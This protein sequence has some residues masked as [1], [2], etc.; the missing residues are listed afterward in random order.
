MSRQSLSDKLLSNL[1]LGQTLNLIPKKTTKPSTASLTASNLVS[2]TTA[3]KNKTTSNKDPLSQLGFTP[4]PNELNYFD[5]PTYHFK[6]SMIADSSTDIKNSNK[7]I[8]AESGATELNIL[9]VR[10]SECLAPNFKTKNTQWISFEI[11]IFE[12]MGADFYNKLAEA[13]EIL[14]VSNIQKCF[15][16]L[17]LYF[18]GYDPTSGKPSIING[19]KWNWPL[20]IVDITSQLDASGCKHTLNMIVAFCAASTDTYNVIPQSFKLDGKTLGDILDSLATNMNQQ[21]LSTYLFPMI[22]YKFKYLPY[23]GSDSP[24][25]TPGDHI[26]N[27]SD[28]TDVI[29]RNPDGAQ[30]AS[31][32]TIDAL[33]GSLMSNSTTACQLI[34]PGRKTTN[35]P[36]D[37]ENKKPN[38]YY[39]TIKTD[40]KL[41]AYHNLYGD[42]EREITYTLVPYDLTRLYGNFSKTD[43]ISNKDYNIKKLKYII[44]KKY[45]NKL[46]DYIFTGNNTEVLSFDIQSNFSYYAIQDYMYGMNHNNSISLGQTDTSNIAPTN[47]NNMQNSI[48]TQGGATS[49]IQNQILQNLSFQKDLAARKKKLNDAKIRLQ[50]NPSDK[51]LAAN[52]AAIEPEINGLEISVNRNTQNLINSDAYKNYVASETQARQTKAQ[53]LAS[54]PTESYLDSYDVSTLKSSTISNSPQISLKYDVFDQTSTSN[55]NID[56]APDNRRSMFMSMLQQLYEPTGSSL[57]S[58]ALKVRGDPYWLGASFMGEN[59]NSLDVATALEQDSVSLSGFPYSLLNETTFVLRFNAPSGYDSNNNV[60]L[61][62]NNYYS[63]FYNCIQVDHIFDGGEYT[64][65]LNGVLIPGT[66]YTKILGS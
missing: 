47:I 24:V 55:Y 4:V 33:I 63:G 32:T 34:N 16:N 17:E 31:G 52:I 41:G 43:D 46:Y 19:R 62:K 5:N 49:N 26:V 25:K 8:I 48:K 27:M 14:Q 66:D 12:P 65:I 9:S 54:Q 23:P 3:D 30:V 60:I 38:C 39:V 7:V 45:M 36:V 56:S 64:Q 2:T 58:V 51:E 13:A 61:N 21:I 20:T 18:L 28:S 37:P 42:Y 57:L 29:T 1:D 40:I 44:D 6:L 15:Y 11:Q 10:S 53:K 22:T 35:E 50:N 59:Y